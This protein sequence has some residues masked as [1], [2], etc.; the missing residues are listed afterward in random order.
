MWTNLA[1]ETHDRT[2]ENY[3]DPV[4]QLCWEIQRQATTTPLME[5]LR[6][7]TGS[8]SGVFSGEN[9]APGH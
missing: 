4:F 9:I 6:P 7:G 5:A 1:E 2:P 3:G 8:Q